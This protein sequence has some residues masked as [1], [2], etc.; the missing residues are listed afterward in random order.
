[1]VACDHLVL[2]LSSLWGGSPSLHTRHESMPLYWRTDGQAGRLADTV[3]DGRVIKS[4]QFIIAIKKHCTKTNYE[5]LPFLFSFPRFTWQ[6][7]QNHFPLGT[8]LIFRQVVWYHC[9]GQSLLSQQIIL[10]LFAFLQ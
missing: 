8:F 6:L 1:M 7:G 10:P 3:L 9:T 2:F 4:C 5:D